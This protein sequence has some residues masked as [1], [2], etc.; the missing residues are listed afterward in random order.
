VALITILFKD[1]IALTFLK[2]SDYST[3]IIL[4][5][6]SIITISIHSFI[7]SVLNGLKLIKHYVT[8][9]IIATILSAIVMIIAVIYYGIIGALY[10][11]AFGQI[12]SFIV[13]FIVLAGFTSI[14]FSQ[15]RKPFSKI[16]FKDLSQFSIM[17]LIS[18]IFLICA[19]LFV[20]NY[21][22]DTYDERH[23]G[24]WEG[25][26]RISAMY[27]LFIT[28]TLQFYL[29]PTFSSLK[30]QDL[31]L[32]LFKIWK[33]TLPVILLIILVIYLLKDTVITLILSEDFLLIK[34]LIGFHLL[35]DVVK[36]MSWILGN[37]IKSKARTKAFIFLQ[38]EWALA[39][40]LLTILFV[41]LYG[42][43]GVSIAYL[44][45]YCIHFCVML[46]FSR[47]IIWP[48]YFS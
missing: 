8:I 11:F 48:K 21:I 31:R 19:T 43:I 29:L 13:S 33:L 3:F 37:L 46:W 41:N 27:L 26:W 9:T 20:R 47:K 15:F 25:M 1:Y 23:A 4:L 16:N 17:A 6:F 35:G 36:I 14:S 45:A 34:T 2:N 44:G 39:F 12:I 28:S 42:F 38:L 7:L 24:S 22:L 18:P 32:E 30:G 10:G 5:A 40:I